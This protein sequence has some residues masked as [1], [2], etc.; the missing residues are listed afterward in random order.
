MHW[1]E[2]FVRGSREKEALDAFVAYQVGVLR[3]HV[4]IAS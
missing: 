3:S 1:I 4:L 2:N